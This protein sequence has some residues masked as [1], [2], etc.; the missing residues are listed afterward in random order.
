MNFFTRYGIYHGNERKCLL[1]LHKRTGP[2]IKR[3]IIMRLNL[4]AFFLLFTVINVCAK[5]Y[6]QEIT[7][8]ESKAPLK[9]VLL[10]IKKQTG[11]QL[12]YNNK[13]L[14][15]SKPVS[16]NI[17]NG[18][19]KEVL[20]KC[21]DG[22][23]LTYEIVEK[24][25]VVKQ[26]PTKNIGQQ[27]KVSKP[28]EISGTV[29]DEKG[30]SLANV[31]ITV[32]GS[33]RKTTTDSEGR[34]TIEVLDDNA[35]LQFSYVG[36]QLQ[37]Q[38]LKGISFLSVTLKEGVTRLEQVGI[39]STGY[40]QLPKERATGSFE[41]ID[42]A[43]LNR[44]VSSNILDK[45]EN[46]ASGF[47]TSQNDVGPDKYVIRGRSTIFADASPLIVLNNFPFDG[48]IDDINPNDVESIT[49]L[50]DAAAASIWGAR[51]GNGVIV[52]TTKQGKT[53][54]P[55]IQLTSNITMTPRPDLN[56]LP[57]ISSTDY[58]D[59][60]KKLFDLG[61]YQA[62]EDT[63]NQGYLFTPLS[64]VVQLLIKKRDGL[65]SATDA[66]QQIDALKQYD[67]NKD[68]AKY[69]Y[70]NS[71]SQQ[72]A[73]NIS[74]KSEMANYYLSA[75]YDKGITNLVGEG[76][77]RITIRNQNTF[78]L[79]KKLSVET[80]LNFIQ[81]TYS[82]GENLGVNTQSNTQ[83]KLYPYAQLADASGNA[84]P[85]YTH[86]TEPFVKAS[87]EQGLLDWEYR[88]LDEIN[89]R[90]FQVRAKELVANAGINYNLLPG[91]DLALKYQFLYSSNGTNDTHD[92]DAYYTRNLINNFTQIDE[93]G[94]LSRPIPIGEML[95]QQSLEAY[96]HQVRAQLGY[97]KEWAEKHQV[98]AIAG[99]EIKDYKT[100]GFS[101]DFYGYDQKG[102]ISSSGLNY[103]TDYPQYE[104]GILAPYV[105]AR[106]PNLSSISGTTDRFYSYYANASYTN[107][108]RYIVSL[109]GRVDA[110]NL[111]GV[112]TNQKQ[113]P[114]WS[115]GL[116]WQINKEP[117][118][119]VNWLPYL[120]LR[121]SYGSQ[122][123]VSKK[124]SAYTTGIYNDG[125]GAGTFTGLPRIIIKTPPNETLR[126]ETIKML[127]FGLD[128]STVGNRLSGSVEYYIKKG[129]DLLGQAPVDPTTG[130]GAGDSQATFYGNIAGIRGSGLDLKMGSTIING[131]VT[132]NMN[133]LYSRAVTKVSKYDVPTSALGQAYLS[134]FLI[135]P[136]LNRNVYA[137]Y[138]YKWAGLDPTNGNPRGYLNG[139][140]SDDLDAIYNQTSLSD[141]NY[142][143]LQ[144]TSFGSL[145]NTFGYRQISLSFNISYKLG[146]YF[147]K[148][149]LSYTRLMQEWSGHGDYAKRWQKPGDEQTTDVPSFLYPATGIRESFYA[150]SD[151][152][153]EKADNIR[154]EDVVASYELRKTQLKSL[155]FQSVRFTAQITNLGMIWSANKSGIDPYYTYSL[156][157]AKTF[158]FGLNITF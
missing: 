40:Q 64:P 18:N 8:S 122:G 136:V 65:L 84:L 62:D 11:L 55:T 52:I 97:E 134:D 60:E 126:W 59:L 98:S 77:N 36:F 79:S 10:E 117:F 37:E 131:P 144:P 156:T 56:S 6:A 7:L 25:I 90:L 63:G 150:F 54:K 44:R 127:N 5:A 123:N 13:H 24:T 93:E 112:K 113:V 66:D 142:Y 116:A 42:N 96:S 155:P 92:K 72:Y 80:A 148:P 107:S 71:V 74:G 29:S 46:V 69:F 129:Y 108:S 154:F 83:K 61:Y 124:T 50:K 17:K 102:S 103:L 125:F 73:F 128:F 32:K 70:Q 4:V 41:H 121:G 57:V 135:N 111:F 15:E 12:W 86:Y 27:I 153:I 120:K 100:K 147:R 23:P 31:T 78:Q 81:N 95:N 3:M 138:A 16:I 110:S 89:H 99:W 157:P 48:S 39:V 49:I 33:I 133:L 106:I 152:V 14:K 158:V 87:K 75:G 34:F 143:S 145:R 146:Y 20:D 115:A 105:T 119:N 43:L 1:P 53:A 130:I 151:A 67:V 88:P 101:S 91:L 26:K 58:I 132:W 109:S 114:L 21:F 30:N 2:S 94:N 28:I 47:Y 9:T 22:Q 140:V 45:I 104:Y 118:Y 68:L 149:A 139:E 82:T 51:A 38:P 85:V 35:I 76:S 137:I 19:V 141:M